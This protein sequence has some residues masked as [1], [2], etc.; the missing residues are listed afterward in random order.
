MGT[1]WDATR[2]GRVE[3]SPVA[4][5]AA[6]R[7]ARLSRAFP[8]ETL[9]VCT[10]EPRLRSGDTDYDF[11]PGSDYVYLVGAPGPRHVL[12]MHPDGHGHRSVVHL[13]PRTD[14]ASG[15]FYTDAR[16]GE[17]WIGPR[18]GLVETSAAY[19]VETA[20]LDDLSA[21]LAGAPG[22]RVLIPDGSKT[23]PGGLP[24]GTATPTAP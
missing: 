21:A 17:L 23:R 14:R 12:V 8:G 15:S 7:R 5:F 20:T 22:M 3:R 16:D 19:G 9:V 24:H 4:P 2:R 1:N 6:A 18:D 13:P 11:R 10:G